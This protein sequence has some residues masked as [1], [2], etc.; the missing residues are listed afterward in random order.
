M[1]EKSIRMTDIRVALKRQMWSLRPFTSYDSIKKHVSKIE[2]RIRII[3]R[4]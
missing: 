4:T 2:V 1:T 3:I